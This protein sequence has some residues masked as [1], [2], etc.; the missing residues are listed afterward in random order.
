MFVRKNYILIIVFLC[1]VQIVR[2][3]STQLHGRTIGT[4]P[5]YD[6]ANSSN[7]SQK[8]G[9]ACAFD[10]DADTYFAALHQSMGWVGLD[11][12]EPHVIT[13]IGVLPRKTTSGTMMLGVLEGA[14]D[15]TFMDAVPLYVIQEEPIAGLMTYYNIQVS[16]G[17]RYVRYVGPAAKHSSIAEL[18][19]FGHAGAG[20]DSRFYQVT[21]LPTV[22]IHVQDGK[23]PQNKKQDF[24]AR[25]T[26]LYEH[27]TLVQEW[28]ILVRVRGNFSAS[29]EN[30]P[31]RFKI[32]DGKSHHIFKGSAKDE[33]PAK[34]K[35]WT[36]INNYGDKTLIRNN[37]AFEVS[38]RVGMTFTP[39]CRNV[40]LLLNGEYRGTYQLTDWIGS[41]PNR[42]DITEMMPSDTEGELLT[43]GYLFEMNG[44]A[45]SDPVNFMSSHGNPITVHSPENDEI[46]P[47]QL[48]YITSYFNEMENRLF[49]QHY[50][51]PSL[52][53]RTHLD[54][55]SFLKYFLANE[56]SGNT[57]MFWQVFMWKERMDPFIYTGPVWDND[58]A[59]DNDY[60]VYPGN[61]RKEWTYK[62]RCA[63]RW[64]SVMDRVLSDS[65]AWQQLR[66][67]WATLRDEG[68][69]N[70]EEVG[71]YVDSL[72]AEVSASARLNHIRWPYLLQ[73][74]HCN[75]EVWGTWDAE[76]DV[77]RDYVKG[78]VLWMDKKLGY[79]QP[80][81][82]DGV[83][84]VGSARELAAV[85]QMVAAGE[86]D[87]SIV[88]TKNIDMSLY[89]GRFQPIGTLEHQFK[90]SFDGR[91][92]TISNL[93]QKGE[94]FVGLFGVVDGA[95][96]SNVFLD[97]TCTFAG[98]KYVGSLIGAARGNGV[99]V[100]NCGFGGEASSK[101]DYCGGLV[102]AAPSSAVQ[103]HDCFNTG[104]IQGGGK[105]GALLGFAKN[106]TLESCYNIGTSSDQKK[107]HL[108]ANATT[109]QT[110]NCYD[111]IYS[112]QGSQVDEAQVSGGELCWLLNDCAPGIWRQNLPWDDNATQ[113]VDA[114]PVPFSSHA[115]VYETADG[116]YTNKNPN[117]QKYRYYLWVVED[118]KDGT[119][120][121]VSEFDLLGTDE[122]EIGSLTVTKGE[123]QYYNGEGWRNLCDN[124]T[125]T[126]WCG[127]FEEPAYFIFDAKASVQIIGYRI[128]TAND[129]KNNPG[130]NPTVWKLY[131]SAFPL[132]DADDMRW[133]LIDERN[134]E[135]LL[136]ATNFTPYDFFL[137]G[138][139]TGIA[140]VPVEEADKEQYTYDLLGRPVKR[141]GSGIYIKNGKKTYIK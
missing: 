134:G 85:S 54:L 129:T 24:N 127:H 18:A 13:K 20:D 48:N 96:V 65:E 22:S 97:S 95:V 62:V 51:H 137:E 44:Y 28:P 82:A 84:Q 91:E 100:K 120:V 2:A 101:G 64:N 83:Y 14:N 35:K 109:L 141:T 115:K 4:Y 61:E 56:F 131:G 50:T 39:F 15:S 119:T 45:S 57:D 132:T 37:V 17:V 16:R 27:G 53:Y 92:H 47:E 76:V 74:V 58:L 59:L 89:G 77:V 113:P 122:E 116:M 29:H 6:F 69:F 46:V 138:T 139:G 11:L 75:P 93:T 19:F 1:L 81:F 111:L 55:E 130:R 126:K 117:I 9:P 52:G 72:R 40:D 8:N 36:L 25:I 26:L 5:Y 121:Q 67:I 112:G 80:I 135:D 106:A 33:S 103:M 34:A 10:G 94:N 114:W 140:S 110:E 21:G 43:G 41:D 133:V 31:Y 70:A 3:Q 73:K 23:M 118:I 49:G 79:N 107:Q 136:D 88:L 63:G 86:T 124:K 99:T 12:G 60:N 30:K 42:I 7:T 123:C 128:Y 125:S 71:A 38:R 102:G 66:D 68:C 108:M 32:D 98:T 104:K 105:A 78:R 90:G 87:I